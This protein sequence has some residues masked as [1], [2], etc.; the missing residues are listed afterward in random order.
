[1]TACGWSGGMGPYAG[2]P[3]WLGGP[4]GGWP[5]GGWPYGGWPGGGVCVTANI[6]PPDHRGHPRLPT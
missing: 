2:A 5:A 3:Y 4:Y 1:M 6:L